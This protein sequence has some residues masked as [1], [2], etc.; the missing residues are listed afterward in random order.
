MSDARMIGGEQQSQQTW[1]RTKTGLVAAGTG[2]TITDRRDRTFGR[3]AAQ[4][5]FGV[6]VGFE[7]LLALIKFERGSAI[8]RT[9][10]LRSLPFSPLPSPLV[11]FLFEL[12]A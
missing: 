9:A 3:K 7:R 8:L 10:P 5:K 12:L 1:H 2:I 11:D 6:S 4:M